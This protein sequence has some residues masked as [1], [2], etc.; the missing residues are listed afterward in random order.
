MTMGNL[1]RLTC[2]QT[3]VDDALRRVRA[4]ERLFTSAR[5]ERCLVVQARL[6]GPVGLI[7]RRPKQPSNRR[8]TQAVENP[9]ARILRENY[10][11]SGPT[12]AAEK[13]AKRHQIVI[14]KEPAGPSRAFLPGRLGLPTA[15]RRSSGF[16]AAGMRVDMTRCNQLR[17]KLGAFALQ[18]PEPGV[19]ELT[20]P[21]P[22]QQR[23]FVGDMGLVHWNLTLDRAHGRGRVCTC[24]AGVDGMNAPAPP[25][26]AVLD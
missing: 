19:F 9:G 22:V 13:L 2:I 7:S 26:L 3:V 11:D 1:D 24:D 4:A 18:L 20:V 14:A 16:R 15:W 12:P 6:A 23:F 25:A 5:Q 10:A 21:V 17:L 8:L